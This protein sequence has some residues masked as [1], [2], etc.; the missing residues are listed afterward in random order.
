GPQ[1][2]P[3]FL[4]SQRRLRGPRREMRDRGE[5]LEKPVPGIAICRAA[6]DTAASPPDRL[7]YI[8]HVLRISSGSPALQI[9]AW[10]VGGW[11]LPKFWAQCSHPVVLRS[12][13]NVPVRD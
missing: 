8:S 7:S 10:Q 12:R 6:G 4:S 11:P 2:G 13:N 1:T 9:R 5:T 3:V